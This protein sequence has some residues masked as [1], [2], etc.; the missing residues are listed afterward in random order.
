MTKKSI[1]FIVVVL[2]VAIGF[3][4]GEAYANNPPTISGTPATSVDEDS[5]YTFSPTFGDDDGDTLTL[6]IANLPP[7]AS[8]ATGTLTGTPL[9][10]HAG[11]IYSN[12]VISVSDGTATVS[13]ESFDITVTPVNDAPK[14]D[15][16]NALST[17]EETALTIKLGDL[18]VTDPDNTYPTGFTLTVGE[19][20]SRRARTSTAPSPSR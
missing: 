8:F 15:G 7:W 5:I 4:G 18:T 13:L 3:F 2:T 19:I 6:S 20:R 17:D 16:Q 9:N 12:I 1:L 14:I 10:E 11:I